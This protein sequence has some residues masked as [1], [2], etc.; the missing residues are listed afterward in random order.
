MVA[1][2]SSPS[3]IYLLFQKYFSANKKMF[4]SLK[5]SFV[6]VRGIL[7]LSQ[8]NNTELVVVGQTEV[9]R[10]ARKGGGCIRSPLRQKQ[11]LRVHSHLCDLKI[12]RFPLWLWCDFDQCDCLSSTKSHTSRIDIS[13]RCDFHA[14]FEGLH[15]NLFAFK[16][17][18]S[19]TKAVPTDVTG[20]HWETWGAT[21]HAT[22][23]SRDKTWWRHQVAPAPYLFKNCH[24]A[25]EA[26]GG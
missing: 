12:V 10:G 19:R 21:C 18:K 26:F 2:N 22:L 11:T 1:R 13:C 16:P 8:S 5:L 7:F 17:H 23:G 15:W 25:E 4:Y 9:W 6:I 20:T 3:H 14:T 24:P